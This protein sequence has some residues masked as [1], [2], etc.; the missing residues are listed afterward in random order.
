MLIEF[1]TSSLFYCFLFSAR[2]SKSRRDGVGDLERLSE[3]AAITRSRGDRGRVDHPWGQLTSRKPTV[4]GLNGSSKAQL[5]SDLSWSRRSRKVVNKRV[6]ID[7]DDPVAAAALVSIGLVSWSR[8][9]EGLSLWEVFFL[10]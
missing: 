6:I 9:R 5:G 4:L 8:N 2:T 1:H 7:P 3:A 10:H